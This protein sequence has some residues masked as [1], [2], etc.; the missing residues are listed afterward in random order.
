LFLPAWRKFFGDL[1]QTFEILRLN[2][3]VPACA[4]NISQELAA[5]VLRHPNKGTIG[6]VGLDDVNINRPAV[7]T[8]HPQAGN[9]FG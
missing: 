3:S 8:L 5:R 6:R 9:D 2:L 1:I 7:P 4:A